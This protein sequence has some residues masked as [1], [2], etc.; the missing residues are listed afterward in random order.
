MEDQ[1]RSGA[2]LTNPVNNSSITYPSHAQL[3]VNPGLAQGDQYPPGYRFK[4][5][6]QELISCYLLCKI[7]DRPL[8][9]N[10]IHEVTL[11]KY[12]PET[13]AENYEPYGDKEWYFLTPRDRKYPNGDRPNRAAGDG[14][15]KA[16]GADI[17]VTSANRV[18]GSKKTLV[19]H[20]GKAPGGDKTNWIMHEYRASNSDGAPKRT[21]D[22]MRLDEWVLCRIHNGKDNSPRNR[23]NGL[24][25]DEIED[26]PWE[27]NGNLEPQQVV[28]PST[29]GYHNPGSQLGYLDTSYGNSVSA[30]PQN[31]QNGLVAGV[32]QNHPVYIRNPVT[33]NFNPGSQ[34]RYLD[35]HGNSASAHPQNSQNGLVA[36]VSQDHAITS[37][38]TVTGNYNPVSQMGYLHGYGNFASAYPHNS[39]IGLARVSQDNAF[40][41]IPQTTNLELGQSSGY[42]QR[43]ILDYEIGSFQFGDGR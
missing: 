9:R 37:V 42:V 17:D 36:G 19:F 6:D 39:Q 26:Q 13:L 20:R 5:R 35:S 32:S 30:F 7:R 27:N 22:G 31:S 40:P 43:T 33:G 11:Y 24:Q 25:D 8:P 41:G 34:M 12:S 14:Y 15:W 18:I 29:S 28:V 2:G 3:G 38:P 10:G 16:T 4:P 23:I 21:N 1:R